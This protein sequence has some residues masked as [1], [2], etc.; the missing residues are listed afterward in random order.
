MGEVRL[1]SHTELNGRLGFIVNEL[2][3]PLLAPPHPAS[4]SHGLITWCTLRFLYTQSKCI[5]AGIIKPRGTAFFHRQNKKRQLDG[6]ALWRWAVVIFVRCFSHTSSIYVSIPVDTRP[7]L[8][9]FSGQLQQNAF[10]P[11]AG[12][13]T[14]PGPSLSMS[15]H[16]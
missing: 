16:C 10:H 8:L 6:K 15:C 13:W 1:C 7:T 2:C 4:L 14:G 12:I 11:R 5:V 9:T 3:K